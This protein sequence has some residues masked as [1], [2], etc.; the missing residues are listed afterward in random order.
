MMISRSPDRIDLPMPDA[1]SLLDGL[2]S[3]GNRALARE[4]PSGIIRLTALSTFLL[5]LSQMGVK[6]AAGALSSQIYV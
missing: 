5:S 4:Y 3:L 1:F 6:I 2:G